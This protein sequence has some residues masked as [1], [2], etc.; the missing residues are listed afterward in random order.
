MTNDS[1]NGL[2]HNGKHYACPMSM[3][4]DLIGGK[5]KGI[6]LY[7]LNQQALRFSQLRQQIPSITETALSSQL[8]QLEQ[9]GLIS[10]TVYGDKPPIKVVYALTDFGDSF[11]P[12]L[13]AI[14]AWSEQLT[15]LHQAQASTKTSSS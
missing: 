7:H 6:I 14:V 13:Q 8:K 1:H 5:W 9:D 3:A 11:K 10:R 2:S 4:M 12:V 15:A